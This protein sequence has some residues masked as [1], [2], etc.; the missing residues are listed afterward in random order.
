MEYN[1]ES[2]PTRFPVFKKGVYQAELYSFEDN[3]TSKKGHSMCKLT[4]KVYDGEKSILVTDYLVNLD[5]MLWK[6]KAFMQATGQEWGGK[7]DPAKSVGKLVKVLL[8]EGEF[9]G[10]PK[11]EIDGY[12]PY[13]AET[14]PAPIGTDEF[15]DVF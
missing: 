10:Q 4:L 12:F 8:K 13:D 3:L 2:N 15:E 9:N 1:Y 7:F 11:N 6:L 14:A 5:S